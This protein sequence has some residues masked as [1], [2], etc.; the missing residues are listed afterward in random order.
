MNVH[1]LYENGSK[2]AKAGKISKAKGV[3]LVADMLYAGKTRKEIGQEL[4]KLGNVSASGADK[5]I[6]AA[7]PLVAARQGRAEAIRA[8]KDAEEIEAIAK[9]LGITRRSQL[10]EFQKVG[11][12]DPRKLYHNDGTPKEVHELDADTAAAI[13]GIEIFEE[14]DPISKKVIGTTKKIKKEPKLTALSEINR[15]MGWVTPSTAKVELEEKAKDG[16]TA[17]KKISVTLN[18]S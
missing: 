1:S 6:K 13:S 11:Y 8:E 9:E 18:L 15:M 4:A 5:W 2:M 12:L 10:A 17:A 14:R 16:K 7:R 3:E